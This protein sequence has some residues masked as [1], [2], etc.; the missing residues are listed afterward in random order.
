MRPFLL[1]LLCALALPGHANAATPLDSLLDTLQHRLAIAEDVAL[2]KWD[3]GQPVQAP[4]RERQVLDNV[5]TMAPAYGLSADRAERFFADQIEANKLVQYQLL[6]HWHHLREAPDKPR[7]DLVE[8]I[9]PALDRLQEQLLRQLAEFDQQA[10]ANCETLLADTLAQ[11]Q[12][13]TAQ[14]PAAIR[15]AANL[16]R[17]P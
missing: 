6:S 8:E 15:A 16:C 9:R 3:T 4:E 5:R 1:P 11:R 7:R 13:D 2:H 17:R 12:P 14:R 10:P